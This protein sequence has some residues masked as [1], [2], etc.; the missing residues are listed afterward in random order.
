[1]VIADGVHFVTHH[2]ASVVLLFFLHLFNGRVPCFVGDIKHINAL[3]VRLVAGLRRVDVDTPSDEQNFVGRGN[4]GGTSACSKLTQAHPT[5]S[6]PRN[7]RAFKLRQA[8][9]R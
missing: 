6:R 9:G 8:R 7:R 2:G 1:M 5:R 4:V 3:G